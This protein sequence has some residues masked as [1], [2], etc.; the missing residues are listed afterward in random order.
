VSIES[1]G[2]V[3]QVFV[4]LSGSGFLGSFGRL[5]V[6]L[7]AGNKGVASEWVVRWTSMDAAVSISIFP[8]CVLIAVAYAVFCGLLDC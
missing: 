4:G 8:M 3:S 6:V 7:V 2:L 5:R 1:L